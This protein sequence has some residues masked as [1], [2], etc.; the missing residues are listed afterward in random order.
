MSIKT[1]LLTY[2][3]AL[4]GI[5]VLL[6][7]LLMINMKVIQSS[8]S[9]VMPKIMALEEVNVQYIKLE[10]SINDYMSAISVKQPNSVMESVQAEAVQAY[11]IMEEQ[12]NVL[13]PLIKTAVEKE[14]YASFIKKHALLKEQ[15]EASIVTQNAMELRTGLARFQGALNDVYMLQLYAATE[16]DVMQQNL[17]DRIAKAIWIAIVGVISLIVLG[18]FFAWLMT[19]QI[20]K[21]LHALA[22]NAERIAAGELTV[23]PLSYKGKDEIGALN[24][25]F[26]KMAIQLKELL[27]SISVASNHLDD[28]ADIL[29]DENK[30]LKEVSEHVTQSTNH[31]SIGSHEVAKS[32]NDAMEL[33]QKM[34]EH[35]TTYVKTSME[36]V[37]QSEQ[38]SLAI[39]ASQQTVM[40]QQQLIE[41]NSVTTASIYE[42]SE[43]FI[44]QTAQIE[45]MAKVVASIADQTNLLALNASIEAARAG[46]HGKG[47]A[48]VAEEVR[49]LAE[50]SNASTKEIFT[51]VSQ[52]KDGIEEMTQSVRQGV[53]IA[54]EQ[55]ASIQATTDA[56]DLIGQQVMMIMQGMQAVAHNMESSQLVGRDVL[57]HISTISHIVEE[58]AMSSEEI[59]QSTEQQRQAID[60]VVHNVASLQQL[61]DDL[62]ETVKQFKM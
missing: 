39:E 12:L 26:T 6:I 32:M 27:T 30:Q 37:E 50:Q 29:L 44:Q 45:T 60:T 43:R 59:S 14:Q 34:D 22:L 61:T 17:Q 35:F 25:S 33:V 47:F 31:L 40:K 18:V 46:E 58:T 23:Q 57:A 7:S 38:A 20:T 24:K 13:Q 9:D 54:N 56:F 21:P 10:K 4:V 52:I 8:N 11:E 19:R 49:K 1:K 41:K 16:Y 2:A 28:L 51:I 62:H 55:Q 3:V 53:N 36:S 15:L 5:S 42:V 48:V